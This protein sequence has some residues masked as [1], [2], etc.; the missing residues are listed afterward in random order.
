[1]SGMPAFSKSESSETLW[2]LVAFVRHLPKLSDAERAELAGP[3]RARAAG[4]SQ[5]SGEAH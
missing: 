3:P 5:P 1:M 4:Q 2:K